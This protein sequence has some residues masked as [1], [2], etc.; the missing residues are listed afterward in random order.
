MRGDTQL[1]AEPTV[2]WIV[3]PHVVEFVVISHILSMLPTILRGFQ[4]CNFDY[5]LK[6][7]IAVLKEFPAGTP[8]KFL[9]DIGCRL[10][11]HL[12]VCMSME[13]LHVL[14][15]NCSCLLF[16]SLRPDTKWLMFLRLHFQMQFLGWK[17]FI[18]PVF[19]TIYFQ[20]VL[21]TISHQWFREW[22]MHIVTCIWIAGPQRVKGCLTWKILHF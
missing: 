21:L 12:K 15:L 14:L 5:S 1:F 19:S 22:L 2:R 7:A 4:W 6:Y 18:S 8:V 9:Y 11:S 16:S 17:V 20:S 10:H 13:Q 3:F